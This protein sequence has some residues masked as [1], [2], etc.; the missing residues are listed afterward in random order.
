MIQFKRSQ[1]RLQSIQL[2]C[3]VLKLGEGFIANYHALDSVLV[4]CFAYHVS[5]RLFASLN[6]ALG[7][8]KCS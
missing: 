6:W 3:V 4:A 8:C 7:R 1:G 5:V 2:V